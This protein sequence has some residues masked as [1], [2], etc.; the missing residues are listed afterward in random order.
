[1]EQILTVAAF[2]LNAIYT[3]IYAMPKVSFPARGSKEADFKRDCSKGPTSLRTD[4]D[5]PRG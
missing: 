2:D 1:M 3:R 5:G 4:G